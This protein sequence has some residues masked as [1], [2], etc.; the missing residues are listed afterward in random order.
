MRVLFSVHPE[1]RRRSRAASETLRT[2]RWRADAARWYA[3]EPRLR[4]RNIEL[5]GVDPSG[6][7]DAAL[8]DHIDVVHA[9]FA[10]GFRSHGRLSPVY[11]IPVGRWLR[12]AVEWTGVEP[13][14]ALDVLKGDSP[15][16]IAAVASIDRIAGAIRATP[17]AADLVA[18]PDAPDERL[19]RLD[20]VSPSVG[21]AIAAYL[22]EDGYRL[23]TGFDLVDATARELPGLLLDSIAARLEGGPVRTAQGETPDSAP[24]LRSAVPSGHLAEFDELLAD[25]RAAFGT[26]DSNVWV[27]T[28]WPQGILR[29]VLLEAARRLLDRGAILER[30][31]VFDSVPGEVAGLLRG[32]AVPPAHE[33][34][35]R[36]RERIAWAGETPPPTFGPAGTAPPA[37]AMPAAVGEITASMMF[38]FAIDQASTPS[39]NGRSSSG[40]D[41]DVVT[42]RGM[43]VSAGHYRGRARVVTNPAD[44][45]K[46]QSGDVLV[47]RTTSPAY[48][49]L[50][51]L[52]GAVVT[53]RGGLLSH[54]A[55]VAREFGIPAVV[56]TTNATS[57]IADGATVTVDADH[58]LVTV[59]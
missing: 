35:R 51:P 5:A 53:D 8:A 46:I 52:L 40:V 39:T 4:E 59:Q 44:F 45:A 31:D 17:G 15:A 11:G 16:S 2:K 49:I 50:L 26:R 56:G 23:A 21:A 18:M 30:D 24:D 32:A 29:H 42:V 3:D 1:L 38:L 41:H 12:R 9:A 25:A 34:R 19:R 48:N 6:L 43:G 7:A 54:A 57:A 10:D 20:Q 55:L 33:L 13:A 58:G 28:Q 36:A 37:S 22:A 27:A 47:A 14:R